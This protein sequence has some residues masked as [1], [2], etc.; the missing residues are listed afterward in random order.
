MFPAYKT[1]MAGDPLCFMI[2]NALLFTPFRDT[3]IFYWK[4]YKKYDTNVFYKP[5]HVPEIQKED[6]SFESLRHATDNF[7]HPAVV[8][9]FFKGTRALEKWTE[10]GYLSSKI[11]DYEIPA[12][13]KATIDK[14]QS[15]RVKMTFRDAY[16]EMLVDPNDPKYL[17]FPVLSRFQ[18]NFSREILL[19]L[20]E[21]VNKILHEDLELDRIYPG[22]GKHKNFFGGQM[23]MGRGK[24]T[25]NTTVKTTGTFWHCA[26]GNNWFAQVVGR[27][28]WYFLDQRYSSL[29]KPT[30][31]GL[32]NMATSDFS[33]D[34]I[35]DNLP[36][37]YVDVGPGDLIYNPDWEWH[38]IKNYEGLSVGCPIREVNL[39]LAFQNNF[40]YTSIV[41]MNQFF[42]KVFGID[43]G[44]YPPN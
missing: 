17:F 36:V 23:I 15:D 28:R 43:I 2:P 14:P 16:E 30:R 29:M 41:L 34:A 11:G 10:P 9:G 31:G 32:V 40:Q 1:R 38:Y 39:T 4:K 33:L 20:K 42:K 18:F 13:M 6:Y 26:V 24:N 8:R 22:F 5:M 3:A 44:G 35:T 7:R 37:R 19:E 12:V 25:T 27:K 21:E